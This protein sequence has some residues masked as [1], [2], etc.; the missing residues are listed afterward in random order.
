MPCKE[1]PDEPQRLAEL[2][3]EAKQLLGVIQPAQEQRK[4]LAVLEQAHPES[5]HDA[6]MNK[7]MINEIR[8]SLTKHIAAMPP[9]LIAIRD[10]IDV[11]LM[12]TRCVT[13]LRKQEQ[14]LAGKSR[15]EKEFLIYDKFADCCYEQVRDLYLAIQT[16]LESPGDVNEILTDRPVWDKDSQTVYFKGVVCR[17][18]GREAPNQLPI[19]EAFEKQHWATSI[20]NPL[21]DEIVLR[22]TVRDLNRGMV[23]GSLIHFKAVKLRVSWYPV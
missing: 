20:R 22:Q 8:E 13:I 6:L 7:I 17:V 15:E 4:R 2:L 12:T 1:L 10:Y 16:K 5:P 9:C 18:I 21:R 23:E 14:A 19:V 11:D 3:E